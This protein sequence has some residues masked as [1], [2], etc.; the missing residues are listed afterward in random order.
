MPHS[1]RPPLLMSAGL[2][3]LVTACVSHPPADSSSPNYSIPVGTVVVVHQTMPLPAETYTVY[4]QNGVWGIRGFNRFEPHCQLDA[5]G[6]SD[7]NLTIEPGRYIVE[8]VIYKTPI[9]VQRK[10]VLVASLGNISRLAGRDDDGPSDVI[11]VVE[12]RFQQFSGSRAW[13]LTCGGAQ[14]TPASAE[15]PTVAE[16]RTALGNQASLVLP[17]EQ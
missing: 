5:K 7:G 9:H 15:P 1:D 8:R 6:V 17:D 2:A 14:D 16:I 4:L 10:P 12:M 3:L 13:R 11:N